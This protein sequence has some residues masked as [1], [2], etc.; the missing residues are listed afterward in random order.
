MSLLTVT[1]LRTPVTND[2]ATQTLIDLLAQLGF[3]STSW[4][5]GSIQRTFLEMMAYVYALMTTLVASLVTFC[6]NELAEAEA[7]TLFSASHYDNTRIAA[8][9]TQ[10]LATLTGGATGSFPYTVN[11]G[12]LVISD[13]TT[14]F[15]NITGGTL[16]VSSTLLLSWEAETAGSAGNVAD[17]TITTMVTPLAGVTV[18]NPDPGTGTWV[19]RLGQDLET[20]VALRS[21][22]R[23]KWA[24]LPIET[25]ADGYVYIAQSAVANCRVEV[26]DSNPG[27]AGTVYAYIA[28]DDGVA[29]GPE[30]TAI[31]NALDARI[32]GGVATAYGAA[33]QV[34]NFTFT[35]YYD[36]DGV[37]ADVKTAVDAA[38]AAVI[39]AADVGGNDYSP[40]PSAVIRIQTAI[41]AVEYVPT[42]VMTTPAADIPVVAHK[43]VTVGSLPSTA[44]YQAI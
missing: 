4:Q 22:N 31:Q 21:R 33:A 19:S 12:D 35:V 42:V 2:Q 30:V 1:Q 37:A 16:A 36:A 3:P 39:N 24:A 38:I 44:S 25:P 18:N 17:N 7:L 8:L 11:I 13:G 6:F 27:G 43:V 10:G 15:R 26:D 9:K 40:G 29:T 28:A 23:T 14:T 34:Q 20:N 5:E 41:E 32:M